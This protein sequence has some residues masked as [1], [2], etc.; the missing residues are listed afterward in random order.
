MVFILYIGHMEGTIILRGKQANIVLCLKDQ[1]KDWSI[2]E[3]AKQTNSTYVHV[4]NFIMDCESLG[5]VESQKHGKDKMIK[6]TNK[7]VLLASHIE[8]IYSL[9]SSKQ[10]Q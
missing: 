1:T 3:L 8:G 6:L 4:C 10:E 7:G 2:S 9:L 5:I